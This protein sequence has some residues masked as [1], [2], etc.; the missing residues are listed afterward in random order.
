MLTFKQVEALYWI[1]QLGS[2]EAAASKLNA[3]QSAISKRVQELESTFEFDVFDRSKRSARLT[4]KG[5][6]LFHYAK[7][8][9]ERRDE[10]VERVSAKEVLVRRLRLGVTELTALTWLPHLIAAIKRAYPKVVVEAEVELSATLRERLEAD[11]VDFIIVPSAP[12]SERFVSTHIASVENAWLCVPGMAQN[13]GS[14]PLS[15]IAQ[16]PLLTQGNL[17]GTGMT[18]GRFLLEHGVSIPKVFAS[19]NLLAQIGLTLSG[20]G[21]S[22][23]PKACLNYLIAGGVLQEIR[24]RPPLPPIEYVALYR[25]DHAYSLNAE[26]AKL[27]EESCDFSALLLT[28][29]APKPAPGQRRGIPSK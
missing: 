29:Q 12:V 13:K 27:A 15:E 22:Y 28:P 19:N 16:F 1:V 24:T 11:T 8:L 23:L 4:E 2:F 17:S 25:A 18:Y 21:V 20:M 3:S 10:I 6:E 26:I 9:L 14:I 5:E 7:E